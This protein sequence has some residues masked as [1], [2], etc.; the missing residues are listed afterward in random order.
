M[1]ATAVLGLLVDTDARWL[2]CALADLERLLRDHAHCE[3]KAASNAL[4]LAARCLGHADVMRS[5]VLLAEEELRHLRRV[6]VELERRGVTLGPPCEDWYAAELRRRV[7]RSREPQE[8]ARAGV[9]KDGGRAVMV[10]RLLVASL[11]EARSCERFKLLA[12]ALASIDAALSAFYDELFADEARHHQLFCELA[13]LVS[14]DPEL[15]RLRRAEIALIE[16]A[17]V[18]LLPRR[19]EIHG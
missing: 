6:L 7:A 12:G 4:S 5:L 11:I 19:A 3:M 8:P 1:Y 9:S 18:R 15:V 10:D 14:G 16:S 2:E 17:V 13:T